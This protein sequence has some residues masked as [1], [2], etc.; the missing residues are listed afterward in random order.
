MADDTEDELRFLRRVLIAVGVVLFLL[1]LW[2]AREALLIGFA[3]VLVAILLDTAAGGLARRTGMARRWA[4]LAVG[5]GIAG[6]L[7]LTLLLVGRE[8]GRQASALWQ[9]LPRAAEALQQR[10]GI[11]LPEGTEALP[12][13]LLGH[14]TF[15]G[16][17]ALAAAS[18]LVLAV[19]AGAY[20][21]SDPARYRAGL[22]K[23]FPKSLSAGAADALDTMGKALR[24]WLLAQLMSMA[25]VGTSVGLLAWALGLPSPLALGLFAGLVEF[26]PLVGPLLGAAPVLVLALSQGGATVVWALAGVLLIQQ[27]ESNVVAPLAGEALVDIPALVLLLG[28]VAFGAVLGLGGVV[29]AAPITVVA[30]VAVQKLYVRETLGRTVEVAGEKA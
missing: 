12:D 11:R 9:G 24:R 20:I 18:A 2:V 8:V 19:V 15:L 13:G 23:L 17:W 10:F 3:A 22:L 5:L 1:A 29:L 27:L 14:L 28:I 21:A 25:I 6:F 26:V 30:Y 4:L 16:S 7:L